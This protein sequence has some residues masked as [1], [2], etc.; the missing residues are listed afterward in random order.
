MT[1]ARTELAVAR[2]ALCT[3]LLAAADRLH[4]AGSAWIDALQDVPG[5]TTQED[6]LAIAAADDLHFRL[7]E[8]SE[9]LSAR[10][11]PDPPRLVLVRS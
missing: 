4:T 3:A 1:T 9:Q 5:A 6:F 2:R 10:S 7:V 11:D 8:L